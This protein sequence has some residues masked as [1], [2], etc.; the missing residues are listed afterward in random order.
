MWPRGPGRG[1]CSG[2][3]SPGRVL[4]GLAHAV[5][6]VARVGLELGEQ[7]EGRAGVAPDVEDDGVGQEHPPAQAVQERK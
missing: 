4:H 2:A 6:E 5:E 7:V 1:G 3:H